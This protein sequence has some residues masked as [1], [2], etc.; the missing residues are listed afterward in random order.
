M[1][2]RRSIV[3]F[4]LLQ[5]VL[6]IFHHCKVKFKKPSKGQKEWNQTMLSELLMVCSV[7]EAH[8]M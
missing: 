6:E 5:C 1:G 8:M 7:Q 4:F 3:L 2:M